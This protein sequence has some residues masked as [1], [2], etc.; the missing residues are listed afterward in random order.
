MQA[1]DSHGASAVYEEIQQQPSKSM[2]AGSLAGKAAL[3]LEGS[4]HP[5][6]ETPADSSSCPQCES[7]QA[8]A[9]SMVDEQHPLAERESEV[10][11]PNELH[12]GTAGMNEHA[13]GIASLQ[14]SGSQSYLGAKA[15][16]PAEDGHGPE[17]S[18][19]VQPDRADSVKMEKK[20]LDRHGGESG[21]QAAESARG[22]DKAGSV[23]AFS[24]APHEESRAQAHVQMSNADSTAGNG[25]QGEQQAEDTAA[26]SGHPSMIAASAESA[27][28]EPDSTQ[29]AE[30]PEPPQEPAHAT[31]APDWQRLWPCSPA[32]VT[33]E[34]VDSSHHTSQQKGI[35]DVLS[36]SAEEHP[37]TAR[38]YG[39]PEHVDVA[40]HSNVIEEVSDEESS[41]D[42]HTI[43]HVRPVSSHIATQHRSTADQQGG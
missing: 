27:L 2:H 25:L 39:E 23:A 17:R 18:T 30:Q 28:A 37:K 16:S 26:A 10:H 21:M 22:S 36:H 5:K 9:D 13:N 31:P 41:E 24:A 42:E 40:E 7:R 19:T 29:A 14:D 6:D 33:H 3:A 35:G 11:S 15:A 8:H 4:E 43:Y 38:T 32:N 20:K 34:R 1:A 12:P